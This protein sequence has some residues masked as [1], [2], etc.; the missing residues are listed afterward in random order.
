MKVQQSVS[1][2]EQDMALLRAMSADQGVSVAHLVRSAVHERLQSVPHA[3]VFQVPL[4]LPTNDLSMLKDVCARY[5]EGD[6]A[7]RFITLRGDVVVE[8]YEKLRRAVEKLVPG[9]T[10]KVWCQ[11]P[12]SLNILEPMENPASKSL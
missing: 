2:D 3:E 4:S 6:T 9:K 7:C 12:I 1:F 8:M 11:D 10:Y 5:V